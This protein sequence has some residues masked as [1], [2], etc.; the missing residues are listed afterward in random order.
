MVNQDFTTTYLVDQTPEEVFHAINNVRGW[1]SENIEG[2]TT[3]LHDEFTYA[4]QDVH[5]CTMK[6]VEVVPYEKVVW[7]VLKNYF[8]FTKHANEW[9]GDKVSF[10][11]FRQD[12]K[13]GIRFTHWGL[14]PE[15]ECYEACFN[16]WSKYINNSLRNLIVTGKGEPN[17]KEVA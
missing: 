8:N 4:Y 11:I 13:T 17:P 7:E 3:Q 5:I 9:T 6:L 15:Y 12:D 16:G 2:G 10:E 1:W 14:V